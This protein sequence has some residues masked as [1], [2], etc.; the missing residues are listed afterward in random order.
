MNS[1]CDKKQKKNLTIARKKK[2]LPPE[3]GKLGACTLVRKF[4]NWLRYAWII[5]KKK[6]K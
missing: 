3:I 4:K 1:T 5:K 6:I 2:N